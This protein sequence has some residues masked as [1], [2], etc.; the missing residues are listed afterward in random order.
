MSH[1]ECDWIAEVSRGP[2][3]LFVRLKPGKPDGSTACNLADRV[4]QL[5]TKHFLNRIVIEL[6][7]LPTIDEPLV[8][9]LK[10]VSDWIAERDGMLRLCGAPGAGRSGGERV[11][12]R[13]QLRGHHLPC[14]SSRRHAVTTR[15]GGEG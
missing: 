5:L 11:D 7:Q 13:S 4:T 15:E 9:E 2:D 10:R 6:D 8:C 12:L 14:Y 1:H 3:W